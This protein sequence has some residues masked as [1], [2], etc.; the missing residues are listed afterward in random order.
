[1]LKIIFICLEGEE[2]RENILEK[3]DEEKNQINK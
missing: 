1:L 3:E 2:E